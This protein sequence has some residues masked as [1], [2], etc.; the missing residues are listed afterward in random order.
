MTG[1][2]L[3]SPI[4][5]R[6]EGEADT[7][8]GAG[9]LEVPSVHGWGWAAF[10]RIGFVYL[11][12]GGLVFPTGPVGSFIYKVWNAAQPFYQ[13]HIAHLDQGAPS[14]R[15]SSHSLHY[16]LYPILFA[17][18]VGGI[19]TLIDRRRKHDAM[20]HE[21][22]RLF[23]RYSLAAMVFYYGGEKFIGDQGGWALEPGYQLQ[24][25]GEISGFTAMMTWLSYSA[26]YAW[27]AGWAEAGAGVLMFFRRFT[28]LGALLCLGDMGMVW[29]IN[30]SYWDWWGGAAFSPIHFMPAALFLLAPQFAR[31]ADFFVLN[32]PVAMRF[33]MLRPPAWFRYGAMAVK[34]VAVPWII[35]SEVGSSWFHGKAVHTY[36]PLTGVYRVEEFERNGVIEPVSAEYP[37]RW[38]EVAISSLGSTVGVLSDFYI[39]TVGERRIAMSVVWPDLIETFREDPMLRLRLENAQKRVKMT[40]PTEGDL[41]LKGSFST[42]LAGPPPKW[43]KPRDAGSLHYV[44]TGRDQV[45][46]EGTLDGEKLRVRLRRVALDTLPYFR[47]RWKPI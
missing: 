14:F 21:A 10:I 46:L 43:G 22:A 23:A 35:Y 7:R 33:D 32:K 25:S 19:W 45:A 31:F 39:R 4:R 41:P 27:F 2:V 40:A 1:A 16:F 28:T 34:V 8:Q 26:L 5:A 37:D 24:L 12:P 6:S 15:S 17:V 11:L 3:E 9:V 38:R 42:E 13:R 30:Q 44:R 47:H 18:V 20:I 36:S 29:L